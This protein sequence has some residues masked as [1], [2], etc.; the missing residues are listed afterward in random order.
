[1][2]GKLIVFEGLDGSGKA[3]QTQLFY[4]FL[5]NKGLRVRHVSFPDYTSPSSA[6]VKLY[7][8]GAFGSDPQ[9]VNPYAA[10]SFYTVD[11]FASYQ[12]V[13][14]ADYESGAYILAD[15]YTTSN[16]V[17]QLPK[18]P[19]TQWDAFI[20]WLL[21][22]EY[23]KCEL[24]RPDMTLYLD[25]PPKVSQ[26]LLENRYA[27]DTSQ[28]DIHEK[29]TAFQAACR[30]AALYA[31]KQLHWTIVPCM[32]KNRLRSPDAI[33]ADIQLAVKKCLP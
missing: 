29:D 9:K 8:S 15:R 3:T 19:R 32:G 16:L 7:L 31:A 23:Q 12:Q 18:L 24:P 25:T 14:K 30:E 13:W 17:Y 22:F 2:P 28:E 20:E 5:Q 4:T 26:K 27:G 11:R 1:M 6:L 10:A 33:H 21:D